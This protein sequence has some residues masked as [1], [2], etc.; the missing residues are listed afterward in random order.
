MRITRL[1]FGSLLSYSPRGNSG[2]KDQARDVMLAIKRDGFV[3]EQPQIPMSQ[4]IA[5]TV[6][7]QGPQLPFASFFQPSTVLVPVPGSSLMRPG[8]L[9]VPDRIATALA[10]MGLGRE[11]VACLVRAT[12]L[13]KAAWADP[14]VRPKP[15][16]HIETIS[17]QGRISEPPPNEIL[18]VDDIVTRGATLLGAANR[19]AEAFPT[20]RIRAFAA[21]RTISEPSEFVATYEPVSG[22]I[23]YRELTEDTIRRP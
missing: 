11:V 10:E 12:A 21:M 6:Q 9:W 22:T 7:Q 19:L 17:L 3:D 14:L 4:W 23:H 2:E 13:R 5:R 1:D 15:K 8:T 20:S 16:E 18:L